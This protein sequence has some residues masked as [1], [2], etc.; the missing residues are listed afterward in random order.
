M[1]SSP[2]RILTAISACLFIAAC[3]NPGVRPDNALQAAEAAVTEAESAGARDVDPVLLNQ[4]RSKLDTARRQIEQ[5]QYREAERTLNEAQ[6]EAQL[7]KARAETR[8]ARQAVD[9][10]D[11]NIHLLREQ[12]KQ[13]DRN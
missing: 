10:M 12:I 7:A 13:P 6:I 5:E 1:F 2:T 3:S 4:A 11:T 9:E 8:A